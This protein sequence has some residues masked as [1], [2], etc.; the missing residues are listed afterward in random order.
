MCLLNGTVGGTLNSTVDFGQIEEELK[1][2][3]IIRK[4]KLPIKE[5]IRDMIH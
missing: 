4:R 3:K 1:I 5:I 2:S